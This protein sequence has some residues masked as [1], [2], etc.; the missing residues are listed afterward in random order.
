MLCENQHI[1]LKTVKTLNLA[2]LLLI[3]LDS[4]KHDCSEFMDKVFSSWPDLIYE[5]IG[6]PGVEC[7]T[8]GSSFV[9]DDTCFSRYTVL[10]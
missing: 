4:L 8:D 3:H 7:F 2:T 1:W 5:P 6:N 9:R 10:N